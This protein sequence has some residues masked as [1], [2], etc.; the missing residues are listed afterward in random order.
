MTERGRG[1]AFAVDLVALYI[2]FLFLSRRGVV[3]VHH[4][5]YY[6]LGTNETVILVFFFVLVRL[7][8]CVYNLTRCILLF[9]CFISFHF[10]CL[11]YFS[12]I[13]CI[14]SYPRNT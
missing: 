10:I 4:P 14:S 6:C 5:Y 9:V 11:C 3:V 2:F 13:A 8:V 12:I 7:F 1:M